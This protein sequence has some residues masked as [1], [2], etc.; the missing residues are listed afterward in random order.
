M[1]KCLFKH[2]LVL[3]KK[4]WMRGYRGDGYTFI[5][6]QNYSHFWGT[7]HEIC[8]IVQFPTNI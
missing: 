1:I 2:K 6:M 7:V 5:H 8:D 4:P 3:W